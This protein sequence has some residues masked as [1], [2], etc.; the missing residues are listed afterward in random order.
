MKNPKYPRTLTDSVVEEQVPMGGE[1]RIVRDQCSY[2]QGAGGVDVVI[3]ENGGVVHNTIVPRT[4]SIPQTEGP[5]MTIWR[6]R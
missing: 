2:T 4:D 1:F 6:R 3:R 5:E